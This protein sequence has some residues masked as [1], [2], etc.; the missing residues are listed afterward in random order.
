VGY[1]AAGQTVVFDSEDAINLYNFKHGLPGEVFAKPQ[2]T[3]PKAHDD[4]SVRLGTTI[5]ADYTY[6]AAPE[7]KDAG[8]NDVHLSLFEVRRA[9]INLTGN[10]TEWIGFRVTPDIAPRFTE[11]VTVKTP[12]GVAP[13]TTLPVVGVA[14]NLDGSA[15][16]RLKYAFGQLNLDRPLKSK[17]SWVRLGQQQTP[18]VDFMEGIY[19]YRFQGTVF[20]EREGYLSSSDVGLSSHYAFPGSYG[21]VHVG[22]YN[23]DTYTKAE[24]N[25]QKAFQ[26]RGSLR[27]LPGRAALK[28]LR[29]TA[30]YD[31]DSPVRSASR[32]RFVASLTYEHERINLG[33]DYLDAKDQAGAAGPEV[34]GQGWSIW[35]TPRTRFGLEGLFR[36]DS[37]KPDT[38]VGARKS[39]TIVGAAYWL[40]AK[41][42]LASAILADFETV[43]YDAELARPTEKRFELKTYFAF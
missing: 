16:F 5:F 24:T 12:S 33:F 8:A 14:T 25:D 39:R 1:G 6:Q 38:R 37:L 23:G 40:R 36:H 7:V 43:S 3:P 41:L 4:S 17:G 22:Y 10:I 27:P 29:V 19:R 30:F 9:Y 15:A 28:G 2:E 42:P 18:L 20:V 31:H 26:V 32:D 21:D 34:H 11:T 35:A 13:G